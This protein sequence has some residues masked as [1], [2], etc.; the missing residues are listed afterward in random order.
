MGIF[1]AYDV[2]GLYPKELDEGLARRLGHAFGRFLGGRGEVALGR[3]MR[4]SSAPLALAFEDGLR[5][6]GTDVLDIG[7]VTTPCLYYATGARRLAGGVMITASHNPA[8]YNGFK[9]CGE[10]SSPVGSESGLAELE[11]ACARNEPLPERATGKRT[12]IDLRREYVDHVLRL[13]G[14]ISPLKVAFDVAN[15]AVGYVLPLLLEKLPQITATRLFFEPD[16]TFP[17]HEANPLIETNLDALR[18]AV[19]KGGCDVGVAFD[20]DGDR[21]VFVDERGETIAADLMTA[22]LARHVLA[23]EKG[24]AVVYDL[25]SSSVV[26]EE[27]LA[28]GGV[29]IEERVGHAFI[30]KTMRDRGAPFGGELS[31]HYYWRDHFTCDS[32]LVTTA[33]VLA[34]ASASGKPLS[35]LIAPLRRTARSGEINFEV[36]DKDGAL[37]ILERTFS[38]TVAKL[39]GVT[40]RLDGWWFNARKSNTEPLLRV[41]IEAKDRATLDAARGKIEALL[42]RPV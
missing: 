14:P 13:G 40:V 42:G 8:V 20:G 7:A 35:S 17:N 31:G 11:A 32:G 38:G 4:T 26:A 9:L 39:D 1:K 27:I 41:N 21:C 3:D 16:G 37:A 22:L 15:G 24:A 5:R 25:R 28:A 33:K 6:A 36:T 19:R 30:K 23:R 2:R 10:G 29:P 34:L 18:D 12:T